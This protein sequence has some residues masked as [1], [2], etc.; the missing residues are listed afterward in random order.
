MRVY[1]NLKSLLFIK[2]AMPQKRII[3][4]LQQR[5]KSS[6][7]DLIKKSNSGYSSLK[8][9]QDKGVVNIEEERV[10]RDFKYDKE[11]QASPDV[12]LNIYQ[13]QCLHSVSFAVKANQFKAFLVEG[14]AGSGK[15]KVYIE[16]C[17][18]VIEKGRKALV[19][20]P[21]ISLT[22]QLFARFTQEFGEE[23]CVYHSNMSQAERYERWMEVADGKNKIVVGTRSAIFLPF[24]D[25][26]II[27][28]D[29]RARPLL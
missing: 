29:G 15:T 20:T 3:Q 1:H 22:P 24:K 18:Q 4:F 13:K 17:K 27:V 2:E 26:G 5:G 19:L 16:A 21:E 9:L 25:L 28:V 6:K 7:E 14:V 10:K 11:D 12:T 23:V 8:A